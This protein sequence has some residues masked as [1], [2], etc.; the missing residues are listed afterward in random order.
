M[1]SAYS[2]AFDDTFWEGSHVLQWPHPSPAS[3]EGQAYLDEIR[4]LRSRLEKAV[5]ELDVVL[6][7]NE[8]TRK[9]IENLRDQLVSGSS[10]RDSKR[11][12]DLGANIQVLTMV[13][14]IFQPLTFITV[15]SSW[16]S[17]PDWTYHPCLFKVRPLVRLGNDGV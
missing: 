12:S 13:S 2:D 6:N 10:S 1:M 15:S 8:R 16:S 3:S 9:D 17:S 14:M 7:L 11:A 5:S 4:W